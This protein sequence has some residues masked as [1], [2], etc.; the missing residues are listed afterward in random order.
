[1]PRH[2]GAKLFVAALLVFLFAPVVIVVMFSFNSSAELHL[3]GLST[4]W[5][6]DVFADP[7]AM[8]ALK[9]S[10]I[11]AAATAVGA[12]ALGM[13]AAL[14]LM[15]VP[16]RL[17]PIALGLSALPIAVPGLMIAFGLAVL[18]RQL[19]FEQ[20]LG[21]TISG[22]V[23]IALPFVLL[24]M[25]SALDRFSFS[26]LEAGRDLGASAPRLY[27]SIVL[28]ILRPAIEG[29]ALLA[30]AVSLDEFLIAF[31]TAGADT[32]LPMLIWARVVR[33]VD[34]SLNALAALL[35]IA[36]TALALLAARRTRPRW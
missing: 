16:Q 36:T 17:R 3:A 4:R 30:M 1:M 28:P 26:M 31:F 34:P 27:W 10:A 18:Y 15:R 6:Q 8:Q 19:N 14:A 35:L 20:S 33:G 23:L 12:L 24:T 5:Y 13:S 29:A 9:H 22:H 11:A 2:L 7:E 21:L 32:T 25:S